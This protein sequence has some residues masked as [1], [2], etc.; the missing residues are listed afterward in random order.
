MESPITYVY[1]QSELPPITDEI[2]SEIAEIDFDVANLILKY[3]GN[4]LAL[5][6]LAEACADWMNEAESNMHNIRIISDGDSEETVPRVIG[7]TDLPTREKQL[8]IS[9]AIAST[10]AIK[11]I[12]TL[13]G[14]SFDE[15]ANH[16]ANIG[17][18]QL[19]GMTPE[20]IED[21]VA[22][23]AKSLHESPGET[24]FVVRA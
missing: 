10:A 22:R 20:Q 1:R 18:T 5:L 19:E 15:A 9:T 2:Q 6:A 11:M 21:I 8:I 14:C 13:L 17:G 7:F 16:I 3:Q 23:L 12:A 24:F 4:Y